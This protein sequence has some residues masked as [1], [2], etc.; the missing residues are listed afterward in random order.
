MIQLLKS[1]GLTCCVL[2]RLCMLTGTELL[3]RTWM[4]SAFLASSVTSILMLAAAADAFTLHDK[5][6]S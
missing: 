2:S 5:D 6:V 4:R 1:I 3:S